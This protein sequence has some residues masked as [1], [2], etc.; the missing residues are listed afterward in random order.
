MVVWNGWEEEDDGE[1]C[2]RDWFSCGRCS[3]DKR[4]C[5]VEVLMKDGMLVGGRKILEAY[6]R[7][8]GVEENEASSTSNKMDHGRQTVP[9]Y[10]LCS[11]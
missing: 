3:D 6:V 9:R 10:S 5:R 7:I 2:T 1:G 4:T 8:R 11:I